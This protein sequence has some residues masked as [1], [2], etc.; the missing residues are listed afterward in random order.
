MGVR[1]RRSIKL[2]PGVRLNV[3]KTGFGV[4]AGGKAARY[5]VHSSGRR[6]VGLGLPGTGTYYQQSSGGGSRGGTSARA[7]DRQQALPAIDPT[8]LIPKPGLLASVAERAY[9]RGLISYL[10]G[11]YAAALESFEWVLSTDSSAASASLFAGVAANSIGD[12]P[13]AI[14]HLES[15]VGS[16]NGLPDR[17]QAKFLPPGLSLTLVVRI[18]DSVT[19]A[20][21]FGELAAALALAELYQ[22]AG[23]LEEAIGLLQQL[24]ESLPDPLVRLSLCDLLYADADYGAVI[25]TSSGV[26]NESDVEVE[27]MHLRGAAFLATD[28]PTAA[29]ETLTTALAKTSNREGRLLNAVRYDRAIVLEQLGQ[30]K[31]A[32]DDLERVYAVDPEFEDVKERLAAAP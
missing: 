2:A 13:R 27:T 11:D 25:E 21:P 18:T 23:R 8:Q 4:T 15:V 32:R 31:R 30:P 22:T 7:N 5:S 3:T 20:P 26:T 6:T 1:F 10:G 28:H 29:L 14:K 17:Y 16:A 19:A 12:A 24:N 9:H